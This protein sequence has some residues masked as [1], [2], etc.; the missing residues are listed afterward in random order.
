[1]DHLFV[2]GISDSSDNM[3]AVSL[4]EVDFPSCLVSIIE[5]WESMHHNLP[6]KKDITTQVDGYNYEFWWH[7]FSTGVLKQACHSIYQQLHKT[8]ISIMGAADN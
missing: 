5:N 3:F 2:S 6:L 1:M 7:S 8:E 4:S